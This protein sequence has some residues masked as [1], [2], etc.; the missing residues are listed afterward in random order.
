[1]VTDKQ[2]AMEELARKARIAQ[3]RV[4]SLFYVSF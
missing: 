1:M 3:V 2:A 4:F